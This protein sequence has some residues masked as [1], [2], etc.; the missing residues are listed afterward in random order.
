[1]L[2]NKAWLYQL[3]CDAD[4]AMEDAAEGTAVVTGRL[5]AKRLSLTLPDEEAKF[6][7]LPTCRRGAVGAA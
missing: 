1:M 6:P 2:P 5:D 4:G 3:S 7:L